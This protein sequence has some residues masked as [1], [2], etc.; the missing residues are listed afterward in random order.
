MQYIYTDDIA[1]REVDLIT[2]PPITSV[3]CQIYETINGPSIDVIYSGQFSTS[4]NSVVNNSAPPY[5]K[6]APA[7]KPTPST[8]TLPYYDFV[9][10]G[11]VRRYNYYKIDVPMDGKP[12]RVFN[13]TG[14]PNTNTIR[15]YKCSITITQSQ[16]Q[17]ATELSV[18]DRTNYYLTFDAF[19][20]VSDF[21]KAYFTFNNN[22]L[23]KIRNDIFYFYKMFIGLV[24]TEYEITLLLLICRV[25]DTNTSITTI[26]DVSLQCELLENTTVRKSASLDS[27]GNLIWTLSNSGYA[28]SNE[29]IREPV[30]KN[31]GD[32][33]IADDIASRILK[34]YKRGRLV[35]KLKVYVQ[36][37]KYTTITILIKRT[38][39][40]ITSF[41]VGSNITLI[42]LPRLGVSNATDPGD[43]FVKANSMYYTKD[44]AVRT[45]RVSKSELV[46][47]GALFHNLELV[48]VIK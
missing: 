23:D 32:I 8:D 41:P 36:I 44:G 46:Y 6:P 28:V 43:A 40:Q 21:E 11:G 14:N 17:T 4:I 19:K 9:E 3:N 35:I 10:D 42:N 7:S 30:N 39:M 45:F 38:R 27:N 18:G 24:T 22:Q 12:F 5:A 20:S 29:L 15:P 26:Y 37:E 47:D 13:Y 31:T 2:A 1:S 48:E 33:T 25:D 16:S 34:S